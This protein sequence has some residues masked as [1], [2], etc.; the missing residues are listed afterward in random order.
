MDALKIRKRKPF[1]REGSD[2][3]GFG[4]VSPF[5]Q[6]RNSITPDSHSELQPTRLCFTTPSAV[7]KVSHSTEVGLDKLSKCL[8]SAMQ[9]LSK[10][11]ATIQSLERKLA[12][13]CPTSAVISKKRVVPQVVKL[14]CFISLVIINVFILLLD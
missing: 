4:M 10:A 1:P 6:P 8:N 3:R 7:K 2:T 9:R 12:V 5:T 13:E 11:E 14:S